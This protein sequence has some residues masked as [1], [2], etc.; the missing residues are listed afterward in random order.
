MSGAGRQPDDDRGM[1]RCRPGGGQ[2]AAQAS[3]DDVA[4]GMLRRDVDPA[5]CPAVAD[6]VQGGQDHAVGRRLEAAGRVGVVEGGLQGTQI[7]P[8]SRVDDARDQIG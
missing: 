7:E 8:C 2:G 1:G 4:G 5:R 6:R 3:A